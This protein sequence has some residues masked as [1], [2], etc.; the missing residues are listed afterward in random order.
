MMIQILQRTPVWVFGVF[1]ALVVFGLLQTRTRHITRARVT[2]L[3]AVLIGLSGLS[4]WTTFGGSLL[5]LAAWA[6]GIGAAIALNQ[7][8]RWP[9]RVAYLPEQRTFLVEGSWLPLAAMMAIFFTRYATN[10]ALATN[11]AL[12]TL[13]EMQIATGFAYGLMS[14]A[15]LARALRILAAPRTTERTP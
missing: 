2:I 12:G 15:F 7:R 6:A 3:P 13:A 8:V 4:L 11:P 9:R 14:G 5:A 10:V 1:A